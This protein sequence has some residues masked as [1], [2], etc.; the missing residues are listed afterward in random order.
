M[1]NSPTVFLIALV[2]AAAIKAIRE[3]AARLVYAVAFTRGLMAVHEFSFTRRE[4][5]RTLLFAFS[6]AP[7]AHSKSLKAHRG[8]ESSLS[9]HTADGRLVL[10]W[11][12]L[13][14]YWHAAM[15]TPAPAGYCYP[16]KPEVKP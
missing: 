9:V 14:K 10:V 16:P 3:V 13:F 12:G 5:I 11:W 2:V 8:Y 1:D 4:I 7:G 6:D 15:R